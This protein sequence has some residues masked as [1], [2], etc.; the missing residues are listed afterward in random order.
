MTVKQLKS[1][2][3]GDRVMT[4]ASGA[5]TVTKTAF[6]CNN[7]I[8]VELNCDKKRWCCPLFYLSE[9]SHKIKIP[10]EKKLSYEE[11][12]NWISEIYLPSLHTH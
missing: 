8:A 6:E 1:L 3:I 12:L 10:K 7:D 11:R 9:I 2:K 5:A 4:N